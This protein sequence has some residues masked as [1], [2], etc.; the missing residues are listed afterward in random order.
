MEFTTDRLKKIKELLEVLPVEELQKFCDGSMNV[1]V[2]ADV[3]FQRR[4]PK[5]WAAWKNKWDL[6]YEEPNESNTR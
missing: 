2:I 3:V 4:F 6:D 1:L 5:E